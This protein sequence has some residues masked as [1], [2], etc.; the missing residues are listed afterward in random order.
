VT[1]RVLLVEDNET[2]RRQLRRTLE[3]AGCE[4]VGVS[5]ALTV[6]VMTAH[7]PIESAVE[8]RRHGAVCANARCRA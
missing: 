4:V 5:S 2:F 1:V 6:I 3:A 8:A 7:G